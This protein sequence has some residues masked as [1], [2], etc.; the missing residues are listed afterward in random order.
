MIDA[1]ERR[2]VYVLCLAILFLGLFALSRSLDPPDAHAVGVSVVLIAL[3]IVT[4]IA[5][6][7]SGRGGGGTTAPSERDLDEP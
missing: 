5:V 7:R 4:A 2:V 1:T 3:S 6:S